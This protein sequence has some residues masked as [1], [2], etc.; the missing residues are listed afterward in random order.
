MKDGVVKR[1]GEIF[2]LCLKLATSAA[3]ANRQIGDYRVRQRRENQH[4]IFQSPADS[5]E[6]GGVCRVAAL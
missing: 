4:F 6:E 3:G 1:R 5:W 2:F